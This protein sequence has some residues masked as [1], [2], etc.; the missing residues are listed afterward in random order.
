VARALS[1]DQKIERLLNMP[2]HRSAEILSWSPAELDPPRVLLWAQV[3]RVIFMVGT[4]AL[5]DIAQFA[6]ERR[7]FFVCQI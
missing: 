6:E 2:L 1:P 7:R 3:W 5:F 4:K